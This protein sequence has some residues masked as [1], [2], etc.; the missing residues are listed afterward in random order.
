MDLLDIGEMGVR[1]HLLDEGSEYITQILRDHIANLHVR[2]VI[3]GQLIL[4]LG[5]FVE[6]AV[7]L[8]KDVVD[9]RDG[10]WSW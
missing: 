7:E 8:V 5:Y 2:L 4:E 3:S 1:K 6:F 9:G 10:G